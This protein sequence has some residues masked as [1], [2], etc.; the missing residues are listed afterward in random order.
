MNDVKPDSNCAQC[1]FIFIGIFFFSA[2]RKEMMS[3]EWLKKKKT[4]SQFIQLL[5]SIMQ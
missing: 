2:H 3:S 4:N 1:S 5:L